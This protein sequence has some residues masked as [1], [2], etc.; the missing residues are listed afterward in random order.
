MQWLLP[1]TCTL[2]ALT[3]YKLTINQFLCACFALVA[4]WRPHVLHTLAYYRFLFLRE[5]LCL[6]CY[7]RCLRSFRSSFPPHFIFKLFQTLSSANKPV[8]FCVGPF[9][10]GNHLVLFTGDMFL[11]SRVVCITQ[12]TVAFLVSITSCLLRLFGLT[13]AAATC[14]TLRWTPWS[15]A[16]AD[17][18]VKWRET[19]GSI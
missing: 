14:W 11:H 7:T 9:S 6:P 16:H 4:C 1:I 18:F 10:R 12:L 17:R 2:H 19:G 5:L 8:Q 13:F 15:G 3:Y